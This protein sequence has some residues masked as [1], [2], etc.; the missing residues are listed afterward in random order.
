M[1]DSV[2]AVLSSS[3]Y[4]AMTVPM[5]KETLKNRR[6]KVGGNKADLIQRLETD[7]LAQRMDQILHSE[8][9]LL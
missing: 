5:L 3:A 7:D 2:S 4:V 8:D 6:L 9:Q 1:T